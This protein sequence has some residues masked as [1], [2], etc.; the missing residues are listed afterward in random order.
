MFTWLK[1]LFIPKGYYCY[2]ALKL[3]PDEQ[4]GFRMKVR[5]CPFY[6]Y[7]HDI[8][9]FCILEDDLI[10]DECKICG[11]HEFTNGEIEEIF[12]IKKESEKK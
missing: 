1:K 10:L 6:K 8:E 2:T 3:I 9:G 4:L 11:I 12:N 7:L 5:Q